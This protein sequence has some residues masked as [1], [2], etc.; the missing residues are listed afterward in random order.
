MKIRIKL[1]EQMRKILNFVKVAIKNSAC[2]QV[3]FY[4]ILVKVY[5]VKNVQ[6]KMMIKSKGHVIVVRKIR[7]NLKGSSSSKSMKKM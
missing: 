3:D 4:A 2:F 6:I 7:R 5:F 1:K